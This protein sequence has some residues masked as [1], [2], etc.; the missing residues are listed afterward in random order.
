MGGLKSLAVYSSSDA[1]LIPRLS[2]SCLKSDTSTCVE[3]LKLQKFERHTNKIETET[4]MEMETCQFCKETNEEVID[5][6]CPKCE[7]MWLD[8]IELACKGKHPNIPIA[9]VFNKA[10][11]MTKE[12][13]IKPGTPEK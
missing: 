7:P 8:N 11:Q 6:I 5:R 2:Y 12:N 10:T 13:L 9:E 1:I 3:Y 4:E